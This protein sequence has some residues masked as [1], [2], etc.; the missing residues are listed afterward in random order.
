[1]SSSNSRCEDGRLRA[2]IAEVL[3]PPRQ[4]SCVHVLLEYLI[5]YL[6]KVVVKVFSRYGVTNHDVDALEV[7][8]ELIQDRKLWDHGVLRAAVQKESPCSHLWTVT[9]NYTIDVIRRGIRERDRTACSPHN[10]C[11]DDNRDPLEM[12]PTAQVDPEREQTYVEVL[13]NLGDE[14]SKLPQADQVLVSVVLV[15]YARVPDE[16][17][18]A[19]AQSKGVPVATVKTELERRRTNPKFP[20]WTEVA[21]IVGA[22]QVGMSDAQIRTAVNSTTRR[23]NNI[24][25]DLR[26]KVSF[27]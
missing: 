25:H 3:E 13:E 14:I 19:I 23:Y 22:V 7:V 26:E 5:R 11:T 16:L 8:G 18:V 10:R 4:E 20:D 2:F 1:V 24:I 21:H 12:V 6:V 27:P 15:G 9:Q 17:V